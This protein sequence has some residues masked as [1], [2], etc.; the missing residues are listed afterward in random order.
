MPIDAIAAG[1]A[2]QLNA[3]SS[4]AAVWDAEND[5]SGGRLDQPSEVLLRGREVIASNIDFPVPGGIN[6]K[7]DKP[8]T[9]SVIKLD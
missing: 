1:A 8:Y 3:R 2:A 5:G 6:Q 9:I 7:W 4:L